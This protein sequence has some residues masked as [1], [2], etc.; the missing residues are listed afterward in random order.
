MTP[1]QEVTTNVPVKV[2]CLDGISNW[3][4]FEKV[5]FKGSF[6]RGEHQ[7]DRVLKSLLTLVDSCKSYEYKGRTILI[8]CANARRKILKQN[9]LVVDRFKTTRK[10]EKGKFSFLKFM[11]ENSIPLDTMNGSFPLVFD[12]YRRIVHCLRLSWAFYLT[13]KMKLVEDFPFS[14]RTRR[15]TFKLIGKDHLTEIFI[16]LYSSLKKKKIKDE[17]SIIKCFK[18]SLC[19]HVSISME[20]TELPQGERI[21]LVPHQFRPRF[22]K[23]SGEE[24]VNFFFSLLQSKVLCEEVPESFVQDTLIKHR[25]QLSS[26]HPGVSEQALKQL[27]KRGQEFG[28]N[29][30]RFYKPSKGFLPSNK[31]T[32]CFPRD[33]GGVKGDL[34]YNNR[35]QNG[36]VGIDPHDRMEPFVIGLFGQPGQG[37]STMIPKIISI[38]RSLFPNVPLKDLTYERTCN[39]EYW[40]GYNNQPIV[41]MDDLGQQMS[42]KDI[43]EFQTL[44]SCNPYVLPMA[45]LEEKGKLFNSPII[46]LTSNLKYGMDLSLVYPE[47]AQILDDASFWRRIHVPLH[48]ERNKFYSLKEEPSWIR[49]ENLIFDSVASK[50]LGDR[51]RVSC[52]HFKLSG[53]RFFRTKPE[54]IA[55]HPSWNQWHQDTWNSDPIDIGTFGVDLLRNYDTRLHYHGNV[56]KFWTQTISST[57]D[58]TV[59]QIGRDFYSKEIDPLLPESL[60]SSMMKESDSNTFRLEFEAYPPTGPLPVRV[61]PIREPLKVRTITAGIGD[62]FCLKPFQRAMWQALGLEPQFCLTHGTNRLESAIERIYYNG[63]YDDVWISGDYTAATDSFAI[64]ASKALLE[65][66]LESIDHEPTKRWALKEISPHLLIYPESS[67]LTP[68]FQRSG[69]LMGS[70]LSFPLLCLLNDCTAR[71]IGLSPKSYL[72]NGDDILMRTN[73]E[74]YPIWKEKVQ[75]FGLSLSL[76]KNYV[77]KSYGTVN[78]QLICE[79]RV[80]NSG[81]QRVL[82]RRVQV[83]GECLRDLEMNMDASPDDIHDLFKVV[84]RKKLSQTVRSINVPLSHGGLAFSWGNREK[85]SDCSKRTE[86]LVYVHD[87]LKKIEPKSGHIAIPY[88]SAKQFMSEDSK[89]IEDSYNEFI[90]SKEHQEDF[91]SSK[92]LPFVKN[93][94]MKNSHLRD[95]FFGQKIEDLPPLS[96]LHV[97]QIPFTDKKVLKEIQMVIDQTFFKLFLNGNS[98]Y[99]YP[100]F[101]RLFLAGSMNL[102]PETTLSTEFLLKVSDLEIQPDFLMKIPVGYIPKSF[103]SEVFKRQMSKALEPKQFHL[104][105]NQE[106]VDFSMGLIECRKDIQEAFEKFKSLNPLVMEREKV[107][108]DIRSRRSLGAVG[109]PHRNDAEDVCVC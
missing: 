79:S 65:G 14:Q 88:L 43:S 89:T 3:C 93:R 60:G 7:L 106:S 9:T 73:A 15:G 41:I 35:L 20:Q 97:L 53:K 50:V 27:Y 64:E 4:S 38:F 90:E 6:F 98:E 23:F 102:K 1:E 10:R 21:D 49:T 34:V 32:C 22:R 68:A 85:I 39:V 46:I 62:T 72:I 2:H 47:S 40:D 87:L 26:E 29:V 95:L 100:L 54:M 74:N 37:K 107:F 48:C 67:G 69:Q 103:D 59:T 56:Q 86:I 91:L 44:V 109:L 18:N 71:S 13:L 42:G 105:E 24:K 30:K 33:R 101:R 78:S 99:T 25:E 36:L 82:D 45:E 28:K 31:A 58:D 51:H 108:R 84:N 16:H 92:A 5:F 52:D 66:I 81:K 76:G 77:H 96:F 11:V 63:K 61:E 17:K 70:L 55:G 57:Y 12:D 19:F 80:L 104:P 8:D 94:M 83:L 75:D